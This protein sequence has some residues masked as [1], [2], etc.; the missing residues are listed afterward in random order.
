VNGDAEY[1]AFS[2]QDDVWLP[3]KLSHGVIALQ[4]W[5]SLTPSIYFCGRVVTDHALVPL[6]CP[7]APRQIQNFPA[8]LIQNLIPGCC[9]VLNR[10]AAA[11]IA[12]CP[13]PDGTWHDWW[14]CL[15]VSANNGRIIAG[16]FPDVLYRQH[17]GNLVGEAHSVWGRWLR[18][19]RRGRAPFM[20]RFWRHVAALQAIEMSLPAQTRAHLATLERARIGNYSARIAALGIPG[21]VR[22]TWVETQIFRM[23]FLGRHR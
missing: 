5:P 13:A 15:L 9:M 10:A 21:L 2:D 16:E 12:G 18:A 6:H 1:F 23:W 7:P 3:E 19:Y 11:L 17:A 4:A 20:E 8:P 14:S 22:Q